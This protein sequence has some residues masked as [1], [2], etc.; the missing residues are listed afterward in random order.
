MSMLGVYIVL[1]VGMFIAFVAL[2][3][4]IYW[5]R[6]ARQIL[7]N[8]IRR[9]RFVTTCKTLLGL[10]RVLYYAINKRNRL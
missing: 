8:K 9:Q 7:F 1:I 3:V 6:R 10:L 5:K 2:I 4:E